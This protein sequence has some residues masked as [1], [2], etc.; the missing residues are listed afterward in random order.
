MATINNGRISAQDLA[1]LIAVVQNANL[2]G[3]SQQ[4]FK[5][6]TAVIRNQ[7]L[8]TAGISINPNLQANYDFGIG[9]VP[10]PEVTDR[11][12]L[13]HRSGVFDSAQI[14]ADEPEEGHG[15]LHF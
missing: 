2:F 7:A 10:T 5:E 14:I 4:E 13:E 15:R 11:Q 3:L 1:N 9:N 12:K 8:M 6:I